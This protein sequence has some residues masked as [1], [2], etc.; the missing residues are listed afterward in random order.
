[1][2]REHL[3]KV[4][5]HTR[6]RRMPGHTRAQL[7]TV[8]SA[9]RECDSDLTAWVFMTLWQPSHANARQLLWVRILYSPG[10]CI[11]SCTPFRSTSGRNGLLEQ[12]SKNS[13]GYLPQ[14]REWI[15]VPG[16]I[17]KET[18]NWISRREAQNSLRQSNT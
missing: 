9:R 14:H 5:A 10:D 18:F 13:P 4:L 17:L 7:F 8:A 1:M 16:I 3:P 11:P 2:P 15:T 6:C 12:A